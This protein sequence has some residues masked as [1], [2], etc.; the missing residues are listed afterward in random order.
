[1]GISGGSR[2]KFDDWLSQEERLLYTEQIPRVA[3]LPRHFVFDSRYERVVVRSDQG[4]SP[5][6][7]QVFVVFAARIV[8]LQVSHRC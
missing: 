2:E 6:R 7:P 5:D 8:L 1:M 4:A 3:L